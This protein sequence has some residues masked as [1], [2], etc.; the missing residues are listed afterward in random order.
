LATYSLPGVLAELT[1]KDLLRG[2]GLAFTEPD[3]TRLAL[4]SSV[5]GSRRTLVATSLLDLPG[6]T[7]MLRLEARR[8]TYVLFPNVL[9]AVVGVLSL[10]LL[11]V[12]GLLAHDIRRRQQAEHEL[13]DALA[14]RKAASPTSTRPSARWWVSVPSS[15]WAAAFRPRGGRPNWWTNTSS[16]RRFG[17][18]GGPCL[19]RAGNRC[20][21][22]ATAR[23][24]RCSSSKPR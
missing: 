23:A 22:A 7:L 21:S 4:H 10:A 3:G 16:A 9:T 1:G 14:F 11:A 6:H 8:A 17:W 13:A 2:R 20:S 5:G 19:A 24:F 18:P 12:L 15:W